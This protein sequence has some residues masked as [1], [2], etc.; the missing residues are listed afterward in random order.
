MPKLS[1]FQL[2][3]G[4]NESS[5]QKNCLLLPFLPKG[6]LEFLA[7]QK[8]SRGS[9]FASANTPHFTI[10][11]TGA[12]PSFIGDAVMYLK[13]TNC[14]NIFF[15]G[16]CGLID[17]KINT[18]IGELFVPTLSYNFDSFTDIL[19]EK[20]NTLY[21]TK[22]DP[23]LFDQFLIINSGLN[24]LSGKCVS[25]TSLYH[26]EKYIP[27]FTTLNAKVI[28]METASFFAAAMKTGKRSLAIL[29]ISDFLQEKRFFE[30]LSEKDKKNLTTGI[31]QAVKAIQKLSAS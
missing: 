23:T 15:L 5:V 31:G 22:P 26:Q 16:I 9:L 6:T 18:H 2:L 25:F 30:P 24:T 3:F 29:L 8:L 27:L 4:M 7:I 11:K 14:Q 17:K 21:A 13:E 19:N 20:L 12:G 1:D 10:I 28:E